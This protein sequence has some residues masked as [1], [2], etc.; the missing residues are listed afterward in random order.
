MALNYIFVVKEKFS[1]H[2]IGQERE[3]KE[4]EKSFFL[5]PPPIKKMSRLAAAIHKVELGTLACIFVPIHQGSRRGRGRGGGLQP[6]HF[7]W[8]F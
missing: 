8:K 7:F 3:N 1:P 2:F 5:P 6:P 4:G